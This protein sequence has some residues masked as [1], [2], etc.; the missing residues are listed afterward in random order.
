MQHDLRSG[1]PAMEGTARESRQAA[2]KCRRAKIEEAPRCAALPDL[3]FE[4]AY[5]MVSS[6]Y[7]FAW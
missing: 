4:D 3:L 2:G 7:P 6:E 1:P 5:L